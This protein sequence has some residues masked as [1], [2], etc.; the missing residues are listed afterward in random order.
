MYTGDWTQASIIALKLTY[1]ASQRVRRLCLEMDVCPTNAVRCGSVPTH[2]AKSQQPAKIFTRAKLL[3][4]LRRCVRF[5]PH[6]GCIFPVSNVLL[7]GFFWFGLVR[8]WFWRDKYTESQSHLLSTF[9]LQPFR[10]VARVFVQLFLATF[11][12]MRLATS[13]TPASKFEL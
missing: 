4:Y 11:Y 5:V 2:S 3:V 13:T 10:F 7:F 1:S 8:F 12:C 9:Y 6:I